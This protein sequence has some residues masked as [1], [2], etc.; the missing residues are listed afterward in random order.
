MGVGTLREERGQGRCITLPWWGIPPLRLHRTPRISAS[1]RRI[2]GRSRGRGGRICTDAPVALAAE[3]HPVKVPVF[4]DCQQIVSKT[5]SW[6]ILHNRIHNVPLEGLR[7][8]LPKT[9]PTLWASLPVSTE[10]WCRRSGIAPGKAHVSPRL[11]GVC[12]PRVPTALL[13]HAV[14]LLNYTHMC[15]CCLD[16]HIRDCSVLRAPL[17]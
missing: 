14:L 3:L 16:C 6:L 4:P 12:A 17:H 15:V 1:L 9:H 2:Q 11:L 13:L 7:S 5:A 10:K 8:G